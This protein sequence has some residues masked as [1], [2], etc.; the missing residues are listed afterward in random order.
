MNAGKN[1]NFRISKEKK[2]YLGAIIYIV[3][4]RHELIEARAN[5]P[6]FIVCST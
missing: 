3:S 2:S 4:N 5:R 6:V 1:T